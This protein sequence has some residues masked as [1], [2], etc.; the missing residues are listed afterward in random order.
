MRALLM[1]LSPP[2]MPRDN[3]SR[4]S[5]ALGLAV[6]KRNI[7]T[8]NLL[9]P[10]SASAVRIFFLPTRLFLYNTR[11]RRLELRNTRE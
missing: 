3:V 2:V 11:G 6:E 9:V 4:A 8:R 1:V 7:G 10:A 5:A